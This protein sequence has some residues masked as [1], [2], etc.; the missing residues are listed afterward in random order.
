[1]YRT[2]VIPSLG[3]SHNEYAKEKNFLSNHNVVQASVNED[4][5]GVTWEARRNA[6]TTYTNPR[7]QT[8][9]LSESQATKTVY[10]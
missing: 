1:M 7:L 5:Q 3:Q 8:S 4:I 10:M 6:A 2:V 9:Q